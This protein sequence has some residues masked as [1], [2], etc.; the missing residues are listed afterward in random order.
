MDDATSWMGV[1]V[2]PLFGELLL[3]ARLISPEDL[4]Q[5]LETSFD[6][7]ILLGEVFVK[8]GIVDKHLLAQTV[9]LQRLIRNAGLDP[10]IAVEVL[11]EVHRTPE[12]EIIEVLNEYGWCT[13]K[14]K[15]LSEIG[16]LLLDSKLVTTEDMILTLAVAMREQT[17]IGSALIKAGLISRNTLWSSLK[18]LTIVEHM[19]ASREEVLQSLV[20][21]AKTNTPFER[22]DLEASTGRK[23]QEYIRLGELLSVSGAIDEDHMLVALEGSLEIGAPLGRYLTSRGMIT[24]EQLEK[25]LGLQK[26]VANSELT[27]LQ[28]SGAARRI[29][30]DGLSVED[31]V[32]KIQ[33]AAHLA[34][35]SAE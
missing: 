9:H 26:L 8:R 5:C 21:S 23:R 18:A 3:G 6:E 16:K 11:T 32:K 12:R 1:S 15:H 20:S 27:P 24:E 33:A 17:P 31:A 7:G 2:R 19:G 35:K 22:D 13:Q 30:K 14:L 25:I 10:D 4:Q 28:A 29:L 34:H